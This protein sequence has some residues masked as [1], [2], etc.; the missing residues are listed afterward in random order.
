M[1][2]LVCQVFKILRDGCEIFLRIHIHLFAN[3][4]V[5]FGIGVGKAAENYFF[6]G[7]G[8]IAQHCFEGD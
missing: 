5:D 8:D 3:H 7:S 1:D 2:L 4:P 6:D